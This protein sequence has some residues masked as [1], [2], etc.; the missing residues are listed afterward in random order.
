MTD[1]HEPGPEIDFATLP[2]D[3][4]R[5]MRDAAGEMIAVLE[6][7]GGQNR[8]ILR[9]VIE[10]AAPDPFTEWQHY[11]PGDV[12]DVDKG[13]I[14]FFHAH[15]QG[16]K[17]RPWD[18]HGHFHTF[19]YTDHLPPDAEPLAL[20]AEPNFKLGGLCHLVAISFDRSG[21]PIRIFTTNRWVTDE[22][23]YPADRVIGLLD[24]FDLANAEFRLTTRWLISALKLFRPQIEWSLRERDAVIAG[25][26]GSGADGFFENHDFEV[27]S[28]FPFD[29]AAQI[30]AVEAAL[31][32][33]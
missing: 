10:A 12:Q 24:R 27:L 25:H 22:W 32:L 8:H 13:A 26:L 15:A 9:D 11:P 33:T 23:L 17:G 18:E 19:V 3:T 31:A 20:P 1:P 7:A 16:E 28:S 14:W 30:D 21:L 5:G 6:E 4:L 2:A 29:L